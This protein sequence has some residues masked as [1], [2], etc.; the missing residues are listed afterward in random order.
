VALPDPFRRLLPTWLAAFSPILW[1]AVEPLSSR[2]ACLSSDQER[3]LVEMKP[4][5]VTLTLEHQVTTLMNRWSAPT[6]IR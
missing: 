5:K 1:A 2:M 6:P 3:P 4:R